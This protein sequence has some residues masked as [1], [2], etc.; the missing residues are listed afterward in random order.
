MNRLQQISAEIIRLYRRQL[1]IWVLGKL[2]NLPDADL[3]AY[4]ERRERI[5]ELCAEMRELQAKG[6]VFN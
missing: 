1:H 6:A 2:P 3:L 5:E 4:E